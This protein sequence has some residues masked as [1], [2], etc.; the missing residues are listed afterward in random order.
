MATLSLRICVA[1]SNTTSKTMNFE[2]STLVFDACAHIR[3]KIAEAADGNRKCP[4]PCMASLPVPSLPLH[5]T[6]RT[7]IKLEACPGFN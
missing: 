1:G 2:P 3:Q 4:I 6:T 5:V 7:A